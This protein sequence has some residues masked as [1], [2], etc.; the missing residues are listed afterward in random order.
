MMSSRIAAELL[1]ESEATLRM[2]DTVL[3]EMRIA[4]PAPAEHCKPVAG[5]EGQTPSAVLQIPTDLCV[6]AYWQIQEALECVQL[7]RE[8]L[9]AGERAPTDRGVPPHDTSGQFG[10]I[11]GALAHLDRLEALGDSTNRERSVMHRQLRQDLVDILN[12]AERRAEREDKISLATS[13][14]AEAEAR[15]TRLGHTF[16]TGR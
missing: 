11:Y 2:V 16:E 1:Y 10:S 5:A 12:R 4:D 9:Q 13:L 7:G 3:D 8:A 15:L 14:M 6:H